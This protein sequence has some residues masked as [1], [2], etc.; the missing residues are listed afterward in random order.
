MHYINSNLYVFFETLYVLFF[1]HCL[2]NSSYLRG[3]APL[4]ELPVAAIVAEAA[5][6][7]RRR[8]DG[9]SGRGS[10]GWREAAALKGLLRQP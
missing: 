4:L 10:S 7:A 6:Y 2:H 1:V 3:E 9:C 5:V 8:S